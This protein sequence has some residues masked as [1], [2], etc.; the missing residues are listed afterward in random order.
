MGCLN[1]YND[2]TFIIVC[3]PIIST[4]ENKTYI[5]VTFVCL[6]GHAMVF[7]HALIFNLKIPSTTKIPSSCISYINYELKVLNFQKC[8]LQK[9]ML[10]KEYHI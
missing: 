9:E 10:N 5:N 3:E 2:K 1:Q 7:R 4:S 8:A 6:R